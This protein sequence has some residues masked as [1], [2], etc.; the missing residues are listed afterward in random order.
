MSNDSWN[1][2]W[3]ANKW[4]IRGT[5]ALANALLGVLIFIGLGILNDMK[6]VKTSSANI[7]NRQ[8]K[9]EVQQEVNNNRILNLESEFKSFQRDYYLNKQK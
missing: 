5:A 7:L 4:L 8:I 6:T 3:Q 2:E 1:K 9:M